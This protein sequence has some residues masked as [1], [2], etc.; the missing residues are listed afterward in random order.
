[1]LRKPK[2]SKNEA[3]AHKEEEEEDSVN[4]RDFLFVRW[5][6]LNFVTYNEWMCQVSSYYAL[7]TWSLNQWPCY[8]ILIGRLPL[9][10]QQNSFH[11]LPTD[12]YFSSAM[13]ISRPLRR[14]ARAAPLRTRVT[15]AEYT[16]RE[17]ATV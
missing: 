4:W 10:Q 12:Y 13:F 15:A 6:P 2:R 17:S 5:I 1:M 9:P 8:L 14:M 16:K 11:L 7:K 3:V